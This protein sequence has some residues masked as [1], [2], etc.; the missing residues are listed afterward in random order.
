[1]WS[2]CARIAA[3]LAP[4][5]AC[6]TV[7]A[8][9]PSAQFR[10]LEGDRFS[11]SPTREGLQGRAAV[12]A[13][14]AQAADL[15]RRRGGTGGILIETRSDEQPPL[16]VTRLDFQ[17]TCMRLPELPSST[18]GPAA[19][20]SVFIFPRPLGGYRISSPRRLADGSNQLS[21]NLRLVGRFCM[22][23]GKLALVRDIEADLGRIEYS[24]NF[25][26]DCE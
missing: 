1:M 8:C 24:P 18:D 26:F 25:D 15:C 10:W 14:Y 5:V 20:Q 4:L 9:A 22:S 11:V 13:A 23:R 6:L 3:G 2:P 19:R 21:V 12:R 17:I 16:L 7:C